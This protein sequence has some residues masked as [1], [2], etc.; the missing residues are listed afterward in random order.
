MDNFC[1]N[2]G[3][4][5]GK[6]DNFCTKCGTKIRKEDNFCTKCGTKIDKPDIKQ[7][8]H[9]K[10]ANDRIE[11]EKAKK[12]KFVNEIFESEPLKSI[13]VENKMELDI[14]SIK[15][16]LK[17][18]IINENISKDEIKQIINIELEKAFKKHTPPRTAK[19]KETTNRK[20]ENNK[21]NN[22]GYCDL[23]CIHCFEEFLDSGGG[24]VGD[25][26]AEGYYEYYCNLGHPISYG[27]F[28]KDYE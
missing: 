8:I 10:L 22:G 11:K 6:D 13:I 9:L 20:I 3:A 27:S 23:S 26:D 28:C 18:K 4:K 24:I 14:I 1:I 21:K 25:F 5:L 12:L 2:C 7:A 19:E 16:F 17:N 15:D